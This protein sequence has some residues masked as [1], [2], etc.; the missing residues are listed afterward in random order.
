MTPM[1]ELTELR[2]SFSER[3]LACRRVL[4]AFG[5]ENRQLII[6]LLIEHCG[7]GGLRVGEIQRTTNISRTAVSHHLKVL[8]EAGVVKC[9]QQGTMNFYS[10]DSQNAAWQ[11]AIEFWA[12]A[13]EMIARCP[14]NQKGA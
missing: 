8:R 13:A 12:Q 7:E 4:T 5:D 14:L 10:L 6:K 1:N 11:A 3:F 2:R 9:R